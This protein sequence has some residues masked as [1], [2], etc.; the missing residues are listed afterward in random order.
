MKHNTIIG[1]RP[2]PCPADADRFSETVADDVDDN[3]DEDRLTSAWWN[4]A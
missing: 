4:D 3:G 1:G 2:L